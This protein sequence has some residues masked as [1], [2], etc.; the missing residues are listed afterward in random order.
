M[1]L[2]SYFVGRD[3]EQFFENAYVYYQKRYA[4][5]KQT[6]SLA[7][8]SLQRATSLCCSVNFFLWR[9]F[10]DAWELQVGL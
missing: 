6:M 4:I 2:C 1:G 3:T 10:E 8:I 9:Y 7:N 5:R